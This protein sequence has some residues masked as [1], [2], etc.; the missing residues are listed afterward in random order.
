MTGKSPR[1]SVVRSPWLVVAALLLIW[2]GAC[3]TMRAAEMPRPKKIVLIAGE[4]DGHPAATHEYA[5]SVRLLQHCLAASSIARQISVETHFGGWP[6]DESTLDD[7]DTIVL[8][9]SGCDHVETN[10]PLLVGNRLLTVEKQMQRGCGLLALHYSTFAPNRISNRI[11]EWIGGYFDYQGGPNNQWFSKIQHWQADLKPGDAD[12]PICRGVRPFHLREELYYNLR[13]IDDDPRR[14]PILVVRPPNESADQTVAW[15]VERK[16]GGRGFGFTGGHYFDNWRNDDFRRLLLNAIVWTAHVDVPA[17]GVDSQLGETPDKIRAVIVT[18]HQYP[19]HHWRETTLA[20]EEAL[21]KDARLSVE[22]VTDAEFLAMPELHAADVVVL[23]YCNWEKAGLSDAAKTNFMKYLRSG[24]GLV[25]VH[26]ANG[27]FHF[28]LPDAPPSDWPEW[29]TKIC[30]R[31]WDHTMDPTTRQM[32]SGHDGYGPFR[33]DIASQ[34]HP[35]TK[36]MSAFETRDELYFN[37]QGTEPIE[38]LATARSKSTGRDEPIAF[39]YRYGAARVFQTFLG[40]DAASLQA[41]GVAQLVR[42][43]TLWAAGAD[44][45]KAEPVDAPVAGGVQPASPGEAFGKAFDAR[46]SSLEVKADP[47]YQQSPRSVELWA[48][49]DS[50]AGFNVLIA[51]SV[52]ESGEHWELFTQAGN[53][54]LAAYVPGYAPDHVRSSTAICDGKWH[55]LAMTFDGGQM[56]LH[57]DGKQVAE[58]VLQRRAEA[59]APGP[60]WIGGYPPGPLGCKGLIDE[61]RLSR[62]L[63]KIEGVPSGPFA[64]DEQTVGLWHLGEMKEGVYPDE[65]PLHAPA[66]ASSPPKAA[67]TAPKDH[68]FGWN[69]ATAEDDRWQR[70]DT[71]RFFS[72]T[73]RGPS[74]TTTKAIAI[75]V[76]GDKQ[77]A[78]MFDTDLLRFSSAWSGRF[79]Q[80][81]PRRFGLIGMPAV[82]GTE[83][84]QTPAVPGWA[85]EDGFDD[86]RQPKPLG[87]LPRAWAHYR[88][89]YRNGARV[90]LSY[91]VGDVEILDSPWL[92]NAAGQELLTRSLEIGPASAALRSVLAQVPAKCQPRASGSGSVAAWQRDGQVWAMAL[93]GGEAGDSVALDSQSR[94]LLSLAPKEQT[95]RLKLVYWTG[96]EQAWDQFEAALKVAATPEDLQPLVEPGAKQ[97]TAS[98]VTRG[99]CSSESKPYVVDTLTLPFDNPYGA[100]MFVSGLD[101]F[102]GGDAAVSTVHGDVWIVSGIDAGLERLEWK[103]FA[104]GLFQPLG[105]KIVDERVYVVGRDQ[106][107]LLHDTN[108]DQ[109]ADFYESFNNDG[110][111]SLNTHEF[112]TC[113]ETDQEGNFYYLRGDSGGASRQDGTLLRVSR[114]GSKLAVMA[115]GLRNANGLAIGP[116]GL[117]TV[118][119]QEGIWT[120]ASSICAIREGGFYGMMDV[121][122][123]AEKPTTYDPPLCWIPRPIDSSS[124]GQVWATSSN[125]GPFANHLLHLSFGRSSLMVVLPE[126]VNGRMQG[127]VVPLPLEFESG[128]VRGR[129]RPQ[130]GQLYVGGLK[131]WV[132]NA[133]RDGCLHRVRYTGSPCD[134]PTQLHFVDGGV[135]LTFSRPLD[136]SAAEDPTNYD[137]QQWNYRWSSNYGSPDFRVSQPQTEGHDELEVD[138]ATLQS[139]RRTVFLAVGQLQPV[140]Q[141]AI[142]FSVRAADGAA[143]DSAVYG[144]IHALGARPGDLRIAAAARPVDLFS[145]EQKAALGS[146]LKVVFSAASDR[147]AVSDPSLQDARTLRVPAWHVPRGSPAAVFLPPGLFTAVAEGYLRAESKG[148]YRFSIEGQGTATLTI[149]DVAVF[150]DRKLSA[151]GDGPVEVFLPKGY[152]RLRLNYASP[153]EGDAA[154]RLLWSSDQFEPE[155]VPATALYHDGADRQLMASEQQRAGRELFAARR[156]AN[157]HALPAKTTADSMPELSSDAPRLTDAGSR[158]RPAW[159]EAWLLDPSSVC[160]CATMPRLLHDRPR[161]SGQQQAAHIAAY[162]ATLGKPASG[163]EAAPSDELL[164]A[165]EALYDDL[166]CVQCHRFTAPG[167]KDEFDRTSLFF[168]DDKFQPGALEAYLAHP[169][170]NFGWSR[171]PDFHLDEKEVTALAEAIRGK[172]T[173]KITESKNVSADASRGRELFRTIGCAQCHRLDAAVAAELPKRPDIWRSDAA[174]GCLAADATAR[175]QAPDFALGDDDRQSLGAFLRLGPANLLHDAPAEVS[176]RLAGQLR[177]AACH[178]RDGRSSRWAQIIDVDGTQGLPPE[179]LPA[180]TWTGEKLHAGWTERLLAGRLA[181][182]ARPWL[183]ARMPAF[184]AQAAWIARGLAA[185]H[186]VAGADRSLAD[187]PAMI[188]TGR[189]L[190]LKGAGLDCRQCHGLENVTQRQET[191]AQGISFLHTAERLRYD[192]YRRWMLDPLRIDPQS[193]MLRITADRRHTAATGILDGDARRQFDAVWQYIQSVPNSSVAGSPSTPP[194]VGRS[195]GDPPPGSE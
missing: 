54:H 133:A 69:D 143:V 27:A 191:N 155:L 180:L 78:W 57:V 173:R 129:M 111:V 140:M 179:Q 77:A 98:I 99:T 127:G 114:D 6:E 12:H 92:E 125:W 168:V 104:S 167:D 147:Q 23:N 158:L 108:G 161:L 47:V 79:L 144:T 60:L 83:R 30:R 134:L 63:R 90:T 160:D 177:C 31:V 39:V 182:R 101:F 169:H 163:S 20:L 112:A 74:Q 35:V 3:A 8:I 65:S 88:G 52:K 188:E 28:S 80:I 61:V 73:I 103:R 97:W 164:A 50:S 62:E 36:G 67:S 22:T 49:L 34:N 48:R 33:V 119:P 110:E 130:D 26:F 174:R 41:P 194:T 32:K 123:R 93:V 16:E 53:G 195:G 40:H 121:H 190:T 113:L 84:F 117:I 151:A 137:I 176:Q 5:Q 66:R 25:I 109:E 2:F 17:A 118:S 106:I 1:Q 189:L 24:G 132:T 102:A 184:S 165:G 70:T 172:S 64:A 128:L 13:F 58:Q 95:R 146:G 185:E 76:G 85:G 46:Q 14:T 71:G 139:D 44:P 126:N 138:S 107:T 154:L 68:F 82:A 142:R 72:A 171:M 96:A 45:G 100:L 122:H 141:I 124:G 91:T 7:A 153:Q 43:A 187:D 38:V 4:P 150:T 75:R 29:R 193:K 162:L 55:Y 156:C 11:L 89:L 115:T 135:L 166:G 42:R 175:G 116:D 15:A 19:G 59:A 86:P 192:Y 152:S 148:N 159:I 131:G 145:P 178:G 10:H 21:R 81:N 9:T 149:N 37:Q 157:C 87:P 170:A 181:Y 183:K 56:K 51:Q 186:G 105:V 18:G 94:V 136:R 120:P